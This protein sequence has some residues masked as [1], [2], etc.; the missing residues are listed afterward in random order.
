MIITGKQTQES[1]PTHFGDMNSNH[2][3]I[4]HEEVT[5]IVPKNGMLDELIKHE[6]EPIESFPTVQVRI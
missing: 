2:S 5:T 1:L 3:N 4:K 6:K